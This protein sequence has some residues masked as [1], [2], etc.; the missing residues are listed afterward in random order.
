MLQNVKW[1]TTINLKKSIIEQKR[2]NESFH[3]EI[4][5]IFKREKILFSEFY[6]NKKK[7]KIYIFLLI[8]QLSLTFKRLNSLKSKILKKMRN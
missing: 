8:E 5:M 1:W 2:K 4:S 3:L 6:Y 7:Q